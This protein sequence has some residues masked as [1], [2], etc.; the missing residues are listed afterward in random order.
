MFTITD[1]VRWRGD[2]PFSVA[3]FNTV[4]ALILCELTYFNFDN[5]VPGAFDAEPVTVAKA[6]EGD[7]L[8]PLPNYCTEED[9]VMQELMKSSVRFGNIP[10]IGFR[11]EIDEERNMQFCAMT[12][13]VDKKTNVVAFR[14]TDNSLVGWKENMDLAYHDVVPAQ[15]EAVKYLKEAAAAVRGPIYVCG[16]SKG[17]NLAVYSSA[18]CPKKIKARIKQVYNFDG[19]GFNE[20]VIENE[21][22][23][24]ITDRVKTFVPQDSLIGLLLEHKEEYNVIHS[25][26]SN[27]FTQHDLSTWCVT[28]FDI[29]REEKITKSGENNRENISEWIASM[30]R[31]EKEAFVKVLYELVDDYKTTD[32]LFSA[33]NLPKILKEY[34]SLPEENRKAVTGAVGNLKDTILGNIKERY[35]EKAEEWSVRK[36][37]EWL[38]KKEE[39][40]EERA[41][42]KEEKEEERAQK[43]EEKAEERAIKKEQKMERLAARKEER[44]YR[45][46][47]KRE[48]KERKRAVRE[49]D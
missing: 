49:V 22:F 29:V 48:E 35:G 9:L 12:F 40:E 3:P 5:Y 23:L 30:T 28:P 31:E 13:L 19:P 24:D 7:V 11:N 18:F 43:K 44:E 6:C 2:I 20:V 4:D 25:L 42:K 33:K 41:Q 45:K 34:Q 8:V 47:R 46:E 27:G 1:Y 21:H 17:G 38:Q 32:E 37:E 16:H 15:T 26:E 39:K 10:I 14:G 36:A